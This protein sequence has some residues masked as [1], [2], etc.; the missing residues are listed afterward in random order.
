MYSSAPLPFAAQLSGPPRHMLSVDVEDYFH[1]NAFAGQITSDHWPSFESRVVTNTDRLLDMFAEYQTHAT[2]FMLGWVAE[3]H[4]GLVRRI[5]RDGHEIASHSYWH[6][7]VYSLTPD[8]FREDLRRARGVIEDTSGVR[9]RGFRAPSWSITLDSLWALDVLIEEGYEYD[10]SVFPIHHDVYG[11][12]SAPRVPHVI[13]RPAGSI[14][15]VPG[16]A[17]RWTSFTLPIGGGY[18]RLLPYQTTRRA[19]GRYSRVEGY[20]A[21]FY[22]HP[23]EIDAAQPRIAAKLTSRM[24]HYAN[25]DGTEG[26]LRRLLQDFTWGPVAAT[27]F[28]G[29]TAVAPAPAVSPLGSPA[30]AAAE[31]P[32]DHRRV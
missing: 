2:F 12:P 22:L 10:A 8:S 1:V 18:F 9:V 7:L 28:P 11:I 23:W 20:P 6:R 25:L 3:R 27:L 13:T 21:M 15:E 26:R 32:H 14:I 5:V 30:F 19:I 4:P 17:G 24:R 16:T 31:G 29:A